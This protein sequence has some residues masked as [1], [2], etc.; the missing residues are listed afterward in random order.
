MAE[1]NP[2][3]ARSG[4]LQPGPQHQI[5]KNFVDQQAYIRSRERIARTSEREALLVWSFV[6][7]NPFLLNLSLYNYIIISIII[8]I[9]STNHQGNQTRT[10]L[11]GSIGKTRNQPC[12][13][14]RYIPLN[15]IW[16]NP[17]LTPW[18]EQFNRVTMLGFFLQYFMVYY[19]LLIRKHKIMYIY[20]YYFLIYNQ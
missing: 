10:D 15:R 2:P 9:T 3:K 14:S 16:K 4:D 18:S 5:M 12:G 11:T 13:R 20:Y 6:L 7:S 8:T 19:Y 1:K 17:M